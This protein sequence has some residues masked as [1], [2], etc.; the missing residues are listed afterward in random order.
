LQ[1]FFFYFIF[2]TCASTLHCKIIPV[3]TYLFWLSAFFIFVTYLFYPAFLFSRIFFKK[4]AATDQDD[5]PRLDFVSILMAVHNEEAVIDQKI[6]SIL[7]NR[8]SCNNFDLYIGSDC[9]TDMTNQI[10][11]V[12]VQVYPFI[13]FVKYTSRRGKA[14]IIND[15]ARQSAAEIFVITDANVLFSDHLLLHLTKPF[16][17]VDIGLVDSNMFNTGLHSKGISIQEG[18]YIRMEKRLKWA[19]GELYG[20]L[21]GPFGG[22]YAIR[23]ECFKEIPS[24]FLVDDFFVCM[25]V[26]LQGLK[27]ISVFDAIVYED[28]SNNLSEEFKRKIRISTG[29]FQN[30]FYFIP[31]F[32]LE[33][34]KIFWIFLFHKILRWFAPV[35]IM[36][37]MSS[38]FFLRTFFV[39]KI[40]FF[41]ASAAF[42]LP[43]VDFI[44]RKININVVLFRFA[45]HFLSMNLALFIGF[46][47]YLKGVKTNVWQPTKRNQAAKIEIEHD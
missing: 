42:I 24:R 33:H 40:V 6:K 41:V 32:K 16:D 43:L 12:Y 39:Y 37:A 17:S 38:L 46:L 30:L 1:G 44:L 13:H 8:N 11:D 31:K 21:M 45:T 4:K 23:K 29:N 9:S 19:E 25:N 20:M 26:L 10:V 5:L 35:F 18:T 28:V 3:F 47:N 15:L 34:L 22:C 27:C 2:A 14:A 7:A 36:L